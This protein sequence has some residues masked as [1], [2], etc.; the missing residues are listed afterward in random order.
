MKFISFLLW[1]HSIATAGSGDTAT[2][3]TE[4]YRRDSKG[5]TQKLASKIVDINELDELFVYGRFVDADYD[6]DFYDY[7]Q[8]AGIRLVAKRLTVGS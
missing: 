1:F 2:Y 5:S 7:Q 8:H 4:L 3:S 6:F